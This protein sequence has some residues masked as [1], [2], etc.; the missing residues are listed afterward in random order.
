MQER[1]FEID[2]FFE[3]CKIHSIFESYEGVGLPRGSPHISS[4]VRSTVGLAQCMAPSARDH[5][6][7]VGEHRLGRGP[8]NGPKI[9]R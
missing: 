5:H 6:H 4:G 1:I 9:G 2:I 7:R 8:F 3:G